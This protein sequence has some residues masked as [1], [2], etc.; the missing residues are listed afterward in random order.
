MKKSIPPKYKIP[1]EMITLKTSSLKRLLCK[2]E[3]EWIPC[4][5]GE[6]DTEFEVKVCRK[7]GKNFE[8]RFSLKERSKNER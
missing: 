1:P 5:D 3:C 2:H 8:V 4:Y 6:E 7:C